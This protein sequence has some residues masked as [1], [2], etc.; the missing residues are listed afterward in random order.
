MIL[1][2]KIENGGVTVPEGFT[3]GAVYAGIKSYKSYKPD[4]AVLLSDRPAACAALF[5]TN[6]FCAAPV[7]LGREIAA[8]GYVRGIVI[9]SG[10][11]NAGTGEPGMAAAREVEAYAE[12]VFGLEPGSLLV[13]STGVIGE[14]LP[15]CKM[16]SALDQIRPRMSRAEGSQAA[17]AI[18][19][20]DRRRKEGA[21]ELPLSGGTVRLGIMAKGS[22]MIHP[23]IYTKAPE[24]DSHL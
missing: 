9:N 13:S 20:T 4:V 18:M 8:R 24:A 7:T 12:Q 21:W 11:A 5:T 17:W 6:R 23:N 19:T 16:R 3:A 10:N 14:Q 15:V 22:G 2:R 1:P